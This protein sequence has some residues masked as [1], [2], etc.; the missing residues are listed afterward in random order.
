MK[1]L[2]LKIMCLLVRYKKKYEK[3][4]KNFASSKPL[5]K[6]VGYGVGYRS[7]SI[8]QRYGSAD[9]DP[10]QIVMDPQ[11]CFQDDHVQ[12][13]KRCLDSNPGSCC[14]CLARYQP[15]HLFPPSFTTHHL[16]QPLVPSILPQPVLEIC[17]ISVR[18]QIHTSDKRIRIQLWIRLLSSVTLRMQKKISYFFLITYPQAHYCIVSL[19][20]LI[21]CYN[22]VLQL[23]KP[24]PFLFQLKR[25]P[26]YSISTVVIHMK[27]KGT[28]DN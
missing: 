14:I 2:R 5:K 3:R 6:G 22:F 1:F 24:S 23:S 16:A 4:R 26:Y 20:N 27:A 7:G 8:S 19:G 10:H 9:P 25:V 21:F 18:I 12:L 15:R 11:H 17:D 28:E 13:F